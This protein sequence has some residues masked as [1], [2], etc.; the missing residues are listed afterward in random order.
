MTEKLPKAFSSSISLDLET[1]QQGVIRH[2]GAIQPYTGQRFERQKIRSGKLHSALTELD[3]FC[4][5]AEFILGHNLLGHDLPVLESI[6]PELRLLNK[7]VID[8]LYLSPLAFPKNPYHRLVK[9]YKLVRDTINDPVADARLAC[10]L[11]TEQYQSFQEQFSQSP[12]LIRF[13]HYCFSSKSV[14]NAANDSEGLAQVFKTIIAKHFQSATEASEHFIQLCHRKV[15]PNQAEVLASRIPSEHE[16]KAWLPYCLAWIQVSD[17]NS[18]LPPWVRHRFPAIPDILRELRQKH[19]GDQ[20]CSF[21]SENHDSVKQLQRFFKYPDYRKTS[22]G[23][24]LQKELVAAGMQDEPLLGILPTGGGKSICFQIPALVRYQRL[25]QLTIVISPL[26]AL[27]KDQVDNLREKTGCLSAAAVYGMLTPTERGAILEQVRLGDIAILYISPEQLRNKS[28]IQALN[29]REIGCWV[30]D[31]AHCLSKWG[32][33]FRPDYLYCGRFIREKSAE[34]KLPVPSIACY[35]A[36]AKTDVIEDICQHFLDKLNQNL[37]LFQGGVER[38]N[39]SYEVHLVTH[40]A[41]NARVAELIN[42]RLSEDGSCVVYCATRKNTEE[43]CTFLTQKQ[44]SACYFHAGLEANEKKQTL[45]SFIRG[46]VQIVCATN[47]F[48]MGV[49]KDNVRLVI[50]ADIPGSLENYLQEAGRAGRD[51][52]PAE[53]VLLFDEKDIEAQFK[54][55]ALSEV[56]QR[57]IYQL[58][59]GIRKLE[60]QP[61]QDVVITTGELLRSQAVDTSFDQDDRSAD[62]KVKTAIAWL[63]RAGFLARNEN[64][65]QVFQGKPIFTTPESAQQKMNVLQLAPKQ[66]KHWEIILE[67]LANTPAD[68]GINADELAECIGAQTKDEKEKSQLNTAD[69]MKILAQMA[70]VGLVSKGLL[71]TA[72]LR[73]RGKNNARLIL[74]KLCK[75]ENTMLAQLQ[76]EHPDDHEDNSYPLDIR[77]LNQKMHDEGHAF[78]TPGL[79]GQLLKSLAMDGKGLAGSSG[80][81]EMRYAGKDHF[82]IRLRRRWSS[83][84]ETAGRRQRLAQ[85]IL[86]NLYQA[87]P[88]ADENAQSEVKIEF[89][90]EDVRDAVRQDMTLAVS[91]EKELAAVE[92][93]LL[94]LHELNA[95]ILQHGLAVFRSAMTLKLNH[96]AS[97]RRYNRGDYDPLSRH[98]KARITQVHVMNE[99][100]RLGLRK[101]KSA[102]R[103]VSDYFE[104][105]NVSFLNHYFKGRKKLL[106]L[107]TSQKS[108][109]DIVESLNNPQQQAIVQAPADKNMLVLAGP[110]SGK[111]RIV[112]HRCAYLMRVK[113]VR[114]YS[115]LVL[116]YNHSAALTLRKR[117][118]Q[119]L[120]R[121]AREVTVQTFHGLAMRLTGTSFQSDK[122]RSPEEI[123]FDELIPKA[124]ALLRGDIQLPGMEPDQMRDK[125]LAGFQFVL[126]DEYQDIDA[127]QYEMISALT[128]RTLKNGEDKLSILAVGDD[129]QS[130]YGFRK[131]NIE[132]IRQFEQ[133]YQAERNHLVQN[134][135]ST[136]HIIAVAN[137]LIRQ[138]RDRMKTRHEITINDAR[139]HQASGGL[140]EKYDAV[141]EGRVQILNCTDITRQTLGCIQELQRLKKRLPDLQWSDCAI[142]SRNGIS[143][144][145]LTHIRSALEEQ[146]IPF[147]LPMESGKNLP[148][149]RIREYQQLLKMLDRH[150]HDIADIRQLSDWFEDL[151]LKDSSWKKNIKHLLESWQQET[152]GSELPVTAFKAFVLDYLR[153]AGREQRLG[154]GI[155]L[156][157]VHSAKGM[158]FKVVCLLDGGWNVRNQQDQEEERRLFYV[159][160]TRAMDSLVIFQRNDCQN[161]HI[162]LLSND[163]EESIC[164][165]SIKPAGDYILKQYQILGMKDLYLSYAGNLHEN[166]PIHQQ[167]RQLTVGDLLLLKGDQH[168]IKL[169]RNGTPVAALSRSF[170]AQFQTLQ[171]E[172]DTIAKIVAIVI[173]RKDDSEE[174]DQGN[175]KPIE[176][177]L[178]VVE[179]TCIDST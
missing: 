44:L 48:G 120:G 172:A 18:V 59:K 153:E 3:K 178:P 101:M 107:A 81:I 164:A 158:E 46:D 89:S 147:S 20:S 15:C 56:R 17:G 10:T 2:I 29:Q 98:Y 67:A 12:D 151:N 23:R 45:E 94:F 80:S 79:L 65:N 141:S 27:M 111:T 71:M 171:A 41:K 16:L 9:D 109:K 14:P 85:L 104:Q 179:L 47:A 64:A 4:L 103:M 175:H 93:G 138:N 6:A 40:A 54:L 19:C 170:S 149:H 113:R 156:G 78:S 114:P 50:H 42:E 57:D 129:D 38:S 176:W 58:L 135:R 34:N 73:P 53:C 32:H 92:R 43:L 155:H 66:R 112:V 84:I 52:Q 39:L 7:P 91:Q 90:L 121:E 168:S 137:S 75:L 26:Q 174:T 165:R 8:T 88:A 148:L 97:S 128:G 105:D 132:Y 24:P 70:D 60:K 5:N 96:E 167:L 143:K 21:C 100:V 36:T 99:Y 11:F 154:K 152:S 163:A 159:G 119:L 161:P 108:L 13:Y 122:K 31:E 37:R 102:L 82:T 126:V 142:L 166:H 173:R 162:P 35:T 150:R 106:E 127:E 76:E 1:T 115:I 69:I 131:A 83:I 62:T 130:I 139:K 28:I 144:A 125:L 77:L 68:E 61:G 72:F 51:Q 169:L 110:G 55:G 134:Y 124:N 63:E 86:E 136:H 30:F 117:L 116:C 74:E 49:D 95:I 146:E 160:M 22:D 133:D 177:E 157:T 87:V 145:E 25:G 140:L 123:K 33:D 118:Q